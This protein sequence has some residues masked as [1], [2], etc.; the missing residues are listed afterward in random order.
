M[1][2]T[3][4]ELRLRNFKGV[5]DFALSA[6][7]AD[8][9]VQ[10]DNA[11]G[12][13]TLVDAWCWLLFGKDSYG[14]SDFEVK[15]LDSSGIARHGLEHEVTAKVWLM[16]DDA[17]T[18][19]STTLRKVYKERWTKR[20]GS[21][22]AEFTGHTTDYFIDDVP[23]QKQ[24]YDARVAEICDDKVWRLLTDP[25]EFS[26]RL[27]WTDR[28]GILIDV[29]GGVSDEDVIASDRD[30]ADLTEILERH[31]ADER[32]KIVMARRR[33]INEELERI[34]V[35]ID[36][37][38]R[39][40]KD[41][42]STVEDVDVA[43]AKA[44]EARVAAQVRVMEVESGGEA[45]KLRAK[46]AEARARVN[47]QVFEARRA[48]VNRHADLLKARDDLRLERQQLA[49]QI[50]ELVGQGVRARESA[51][52]I[53][54]DL[55]AARE[56]RRLVDQEELVHDDET[57]CPT[58]KQPLPDEYIESAREEALASF[59]KRKAKLLRDLDLEIEQ[60]AG[61]AGEKTGVADEAD[62]KIAALKEM[63]STIEGAVADAEAEE[64]KARPITLGAEDVAGDESTEL[65]ELSQQLEKLQADKRS[66]ID[67]AVSELNAITETIS[68]LEGQRA[69]VK[70]AARVDERIDELKREER[71][72]AAEYEELERELY[73]LDEFTKRKVRILEDRI[74]ANFEMARFK[75]FNVQVNGGLEECCEVLY[76]GVPYTRNLNHG[77]RV[78]VGLDIVRTLQRHFGFSPPVWVD[79]AESITVLPTM[80]C[81]LI[82]LQ[83]VGGTDQLTVII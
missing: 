45:V 3:I 43:L 66:A 29:C 34:P 72:L 16:K 10:G 42:E 63:L 20:R 8:A 64:E 23:I 61:Q 24:Q 12:K 11:A 7:R 78:Q 82:R 74:N 25:L 17:D 21:A 46:I 28:R 73:L 62:S 1:R 83:V 30:L 44:R 14:R 56:R 18:G 2:M 49:R 13:T 59:N 68:R 4:E 55:H 77:A 41:V 22:K 31:T 36:E 75:M 58:C 33:K 47:E 76:D 79:Q 50:D 71:K 52:E 37:A 38:A 67:D 40:K 70:E 60:L 19:Y 26:E 51:R 65:K 15:T 32:R 48:A 54:A 35:R 80:N 39:G 69:A 81:Q 57:T 6:D 53:A 27:H 5:E 9:T